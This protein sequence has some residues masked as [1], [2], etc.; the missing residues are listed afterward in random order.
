[1]VHFFEMLKD[2]CRMQDI[3]YIVHQDLIRECLSKQLEPII[4]QTT[5]WICDLTDGGGWEAVERQRSG[6]GNT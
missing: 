6:R 2:V 5:F 4:K 1:M 3:S